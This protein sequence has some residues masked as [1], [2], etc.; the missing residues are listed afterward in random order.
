MANDKKLIEDSFPIFN[1]AICE[2]ESKR[3]EI[4]LA[5]SA[6]IVREHLGGPNLVD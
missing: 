3:T 1:F 2:I 6:H 4:C 5:D